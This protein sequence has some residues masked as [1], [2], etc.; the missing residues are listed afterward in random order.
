MK[1]IKLTVTLTITDELYEHKSIQELK[2]DINTGKFQR[3]FFES[4]N[5]KKENGVLKCKA[6]LEI[7]KE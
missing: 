6:N 7:I 2:N 1:T 5:K 3:E 4:W